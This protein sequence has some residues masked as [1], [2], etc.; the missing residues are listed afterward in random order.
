MNR[1]WRSS[2]NKV[3]H[4]VALGREVGGPDRIQD[5]IA[6]RDRPCSR[7]PGAARPDRPWIPG[8][9]WTGDTPM[10]TGAAAACDPWL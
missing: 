8:S 10:T 4:D 7:A 3:V 5:P 2:D 9:Q 6:R 1:G